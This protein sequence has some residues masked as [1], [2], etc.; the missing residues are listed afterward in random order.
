MKY[1]HEKMK[2]TLLVILIVLMTLY[3]GILV[4]IQ[5]IIGINYWDIFVYLNNAMLFSNINIGSQLSVPPVLSLI[6]AIPF[7]LGFISETSL[8]IVSGIFFILLIAVIYLL[9]NMRFTPT[10]SFIGSLFF[11]ML[12]LVVSWSV[13]GST[14]IPSLT[15]SMLA[16]YLTILGVRKEFKYY[17]LAFL[18]FVLAFLTRYS[19]GFILLVILSFLIMNKKIV[20]EQLTKKNIIKLMTLFVIT[21]LI[22]TGIYLSFQGNIP[23]LSQ[24]VEVSSSTSVSKVNVGYDLNPLYYIEL[25][26]QYLTSLSISTFYENNLSNSYNVPTIFSYVILLF[27]AVGILFISNVFF[28][29]KDEFND[30]IYVCEE[31]QNRPQ[32]LLNIEIP[33]KVK[34]GIVIVLSLISIIS[35]LHISYI[36]TEVMF[37][38][39]VLLFYDLYED[40]INQ[41]DLL[42]IILMGIYIILHS[43]HPVKVDRYILPI[44]I[45]IVYFMIKGLTDTIT[46]IHLKNKKIP[47]IILIIFL[48]ILIPI[49]ISYI[50]SMAH[51][52]HHAYEEE[53]A[54]IWIKNYDPNYSNNNISSD[55]G[56]T[57]SWYL[58]K[59]VYTTIPRVLKENNDTLENKLNSIE[60]KYYIDSSSNLTSIEGYEKIYDN[61]QTDNHLAIYQR[62]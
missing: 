8:F 36:I 61:N 29:K 23:F 5:K 13:S 18:C 58:K 60:A 6:V 43:Y 3:A 47:L 41:I 44:L 20:L 37:L 57:F 27:S 55:R 10:V 40:K 39:I 25:L 51:P 24:I 15:F 14:D 11:S 59:Y 12:S 56:V 16:L 33:K 62:E 4:N 32:N 46:K 22:I 2:S 1:I 26:P 48:I 17:Y 9:F 34:I 19:A 49:N 38:I 53:K 31:N 45:P 42:M 35:Y 50:H 28:N 21:I 30:E 52:N 7:R 54:S